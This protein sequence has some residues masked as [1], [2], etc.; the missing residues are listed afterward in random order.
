MN[1]IVR[2]AHFIIYPLKMN[3]VFLMIKGNIFS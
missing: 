1:V 3:L 2:N